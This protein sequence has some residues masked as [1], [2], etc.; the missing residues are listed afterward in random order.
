MS[1][2]QACSI[3]KI[4]QINPIIKFQKMKSLYRAICLCGRVIGQDIVEEN[5]IKVILLDLNLGSRMHITCGNKLREKGNPSQ[6]G[7][8]LSTPEGEQIICMWYSGIVI[9]KETKF[10]IF[11]VHS[12]L[13]YIC[14]LLKIPGTQSGDSG[15]HVLFLFLPLN[16]I[17]M[18]GRVI[19]YTLEM[20]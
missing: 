17:C 10:L 15:I 7:R 2:P 12:F 4:F 13:K 5:F 1:I 6:I 16:N 11:N 20:L 14:L 3:T 18:W 19:K 8:P 9:Y